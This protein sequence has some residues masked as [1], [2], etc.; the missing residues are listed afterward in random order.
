MSALKY[1]HDHGVV[2]RDVK[3]ANVL[4]LSDGPSNCT[5]AKLTDFGCCLH[6]NDKMEG[7]TSTLS[8]TILW[9]SPEAAR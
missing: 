8:G 5:L 2:H 3:G 1:L 4:V 6:E 9:M 7:D